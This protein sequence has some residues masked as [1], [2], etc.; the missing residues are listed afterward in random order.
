MSLRIKFFE[1]W[2]RKI[3]KMLEFVI[4]SRNYLSQKRWFFLKAMGGCGNGLKVK[5]ERVAFV[6]LLGKGT[7]YAPYP[8]LDVGGHDFV[9]L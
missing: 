6:C 2:V 5:F 9:V 7:P 3:V 8:F 1:Q 4:V